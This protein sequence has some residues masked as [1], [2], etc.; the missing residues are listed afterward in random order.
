M[1]GSGHS[2][3]IIDDDEDNRLLFAIALS[4]KGYHVEEA[5]NGIEALDKLQ[6]RCAHLV[7]SDCLMPDMDGFELL[8]E[9]RQ[10]GKLR[11]IPV[12]LYSA[13]FHSAE[14][15]TLAKRLGAAYFL[16]SP[17]TPSQ[18]TALVETHFSAPANLPGD[19]GETLSERKWGSIHKQILR[20]KIYDE[21]AHLRQQNNRSSELARQLEE[22]Q[23]IAHLGS[24]RW[25]AGH[26]SLSAEALRILGREKDYLGTDYRAIFELAVPEE[27]KQVLSKMEQTLRQRSPRFEIEHRIQPPGSEPRH[28]VQRGVVTF[29]EDG[30]LLRILATIHDVTA[31]RR[32]QEDKEKSAAQWRTL[33]EQT[34]RCI[35]KLLDKRDPDT[36]GHEI[37]IAGLCAAIGQALGLDQ[38][39]IEGIRLGATIHDIGKACVPTEV[40]SKPGKLTASEFELVKTHCAVGYELIQEIPFPWPIADMV[41]QHH[42]RL[43]GSGYPQ[44]LRGEAIVL[45]ARILA[46]ADVVE[47][48]SAP[49]AHRPALGIGPALDEIRHGRG[50]KYDPRVVDICLDL[51]ENQGFRFEAE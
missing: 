25:Q 38:D 12:C 1:T 7:L 27:V 44:G 36:A 48:I 34:I 2:V 51:F 13:T 49:R 9:M 28:V 43:D 3:L 17:V 46:V 8:R 35:G 47:A 19:A 32:T 23:H 5:G 31:W 29:A 42:E 16:S 10:D 14:A 6:R 20:D 39:R 22:A 4:N 33:L 21:I 26:L 41:H 18:V 45:E 15:E 24:W 50:T 30:R 40:L 11:D 37:R